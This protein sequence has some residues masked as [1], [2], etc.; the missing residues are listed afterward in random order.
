[1]ASAKA[2][3]QRRWLVPVVAFLAGTAVGCGGVTH[4][5]QGK[6]VFKDGSSITPLVG[7]LVV[8]MPADGTKTATARGTIQDDGS[9]RLS[10]ARDGDGA[11]PGLYRAV[12]TPPAPSVADLRKHQPP[13]VLH[14]RY[15]TAGKS[16]LVFTVES[17]SNDFTLAVDRP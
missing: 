11:A 14:P 1:M 13:R 8:F 2:Q 10:T 15:Q 6:V 12:I 7:G 4:P 5:V 16:P 9:F 3:A 17:G